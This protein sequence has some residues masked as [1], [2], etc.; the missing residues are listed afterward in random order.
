MADPLSI[1]TGVLTILDI[2][3]KVIK[4]GLDTKEATKEIRALKVQ[5][6]SLHAALK[7]LEQWCKDAESKHQGKSPE[8]LRALRE[9]KSDNG[10]SD[11]KDPEHLEYK[12][13]LVDLQRSFQDV[14]DK[15]NP[16][17]QWEKKA[18]YQSLTWH[19]K[20]GAFGEIRATV[21]SC[22]TTINT[23]I[24][25]KNDAANQKMQASIET[26][27]ENQAR[28][29]EREEIKDAEQKREQEEAD[30]DEIADWLS[31][32]SFIAKEEQLW[33]NCFRE[34][35]EWLWGDEIFQAWKEGRPW[36]LLCTG[37]LGVGKTVLSSILKRHL[38][39]APGKL[40]PVLFIFLDYKS[41]NLQTVPHLIGSLL[42]QL[43]QIDNS[44]TVS[45][46]LKTLHKRAKRL[47]LPPDTYFDQL[48]GILV[49]ELDNYDK[50]FLVL[51]GLDELPIRDKRLL[52]KELLDL[53]AGK[54]RL[55]IMTRRINERVSNIDYVCDICHK[56]R[57][58]AFRC[59][60]CANGQFDVCYS[61]KK[62][63][64]GCLVDSHTL[65]E[66][67]G[68][69]EIEVKIPSTDI[70]SY[71]KR[72]MGIEIGNTIS[73]TRDDRDLYASDNYWA[74]PFQ[75]LCQKNPE[76]MAKIVAEVTQKADGRFLYARL[77]MD[78]LKEAK[79]S[80]SLKRMLNTFPEGTDGIFKD[81]MQRVDAKPADERRLA[82]RVFGLLALAYRPLLIGELQHALAA[83]DVEEE[84]YPDESD[85]LDGDYEEKTI[86]ESTSGLVIISN[87]GSKAR[88]VRFVHRSL[89]DF[90]QK[91][92]N[93]TKWL[94]NAKHEMAKACM[95]YLRLVLP[96]KPSEEQHLEE[97]KT[98]FPFLTYASQYW[99]DHIREATVVEVGSDE[100]SQ[101]A[102]EV[103]GN[104][105]RKDAYMQAAWVTNIGGADTWDVE[106]N[107]DQFH[108][109]A[110]YGLSSVISMMEPE[111]SIV[112]R[113]EPK[114]GRTP[115]MYACRKGHV[116]VARQL[117]QLRASQSKRSAHG[118]TA[119]FEAISGQIN[120]RQTRVLEEKADR[121]DHEKVVELLVS[122]MPG[123]LDINTTND[124][125]F[126]R[127]ALMLAAR[128]G[129]LKI[130]KTL[131]A[132]HDIDLDLQDRNGMTALILAVRERHRAIVE[133]LL[134]AGASVNMMDSHAGRT[135]LRYAAERDFPELVSLLMEYGADPNLKDH[136]GRTAACHAVNRNCQSALE[137]MIENSIDL[138]CVDEDG[139]TLLHG[140]AR[141]GCCGIARLLFE[142]A[143]VDK[144][145]TSN[146]LSK[147]GMTPLH[148]AS[149]YGQAEVAAVLLDN[150]ADPS[151]TDQYGR[152]P[153]VVA[154]QYGKGQIMAMLKGFGFQ[155]P[156]EA[157]L[158]HAT[159]PIW[160][161]ARQGLTE[162][163]VST[164]RTKKQEALALEPV[165]GYTC[166]H[167][168][169]DGRKPDVLRILVES[170][171]IPINEAKLH[172]RTALHL[173][174]ISDDTDATQ[175][176]LEQGADPNLRD[177]WKD[178]PIVL[179]QSCMYMKTM[180]AL[181]KGGATIN[182]KK[183]TTAQVIK[184]FFFAVEQ[185]DVVAARKLIEEHG[186]NPIVKNE[187]GLTAMQI[188]R[189]ADDEEMMLLLRSAPSVN[190]K[191]FDVTNGQDTS[192]QLNDPAQARFLPFRSRPP[193][194]VD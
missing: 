93:R 10:G 177:R 158:D 72:E 160:A 18:C 19:F 182:K 62:E 108:I 64:R 167:C 74:T 102:L 1:T 130:V 101:A 105:H 73:T 77:Y 121:N 139:Y 99:G 126:D 116:T 65:T 129:N 154:W 45:D 52:L 23:I 42:Q 161:M 150:D 12:G 13:L 162:L 21:D 70:E 123:D 83:I 76:L 82:Y 36:F 133:I 28:A 140:T 89:E 149:Q 189:A 136:Q 164:L 134:N 33:K 146:V 190:F 30:K 156:P 40:F 7:L 122:E 114:Y 171:T 34:T 124:Q 181:V 180:L 127:T 118:R 165:T 175:Y 128:G 141:Y 151:L 185:S 69:V 159:L 98:Q 192:A 176:L 55:I 24:H 113:A 173:A 188:A 86:L 80:K 172:E 85:I 174:A 112:D 15:L 17:R 186:V 59:R 92:N 193:D 163:I 27:L 5:F 44:F 179:A 37:E 11:G 168:A 142:K 56:Q 81:A 50:F 131:I 8:W 148:V 110:W 157:S 25:V 61:C 20:K 71:V 96:Q 94:L 54:G 143:R 178:E 49:R 183:I 111:P 169:V 170:R 6:E 100:F 125:E 90:L 119:L 41:S 103:V 26:V 106:R 58:V 32:L 46:K 75:T 152:T 187:N 47:R 120:R 153:F 79:N 147:H 38:P 16:S 9:V 137:K 48:K 91:E 138:D 155:Q 88:F 51:D 117:L 22:L 132:H 3:K 87:Q 35:G 53:R 184:M 144:R 39:R 60:I 63:E 31:P 191:D 29:Q 68:Q 2:T 57:S 66:P 4:Y 135:P 107:V 166:I 194:S 115:L 43:I 97:K 104:Q 95:T 109:C 145:L 14:T 67:Y 78:S 84:D